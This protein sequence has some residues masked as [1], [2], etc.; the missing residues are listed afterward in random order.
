MDVTLSNLSGRVPN[1]LWCR[2]SI[3]FHLVG[4]HSSHTWGNLHANKDPGLVANT[5]RFEI[6]SHSSLVAS[7]CWMIF[8]GLPIGDEFATAS[9]FLGSQSRGFP[10][11][12]I[13]VH[14]HVNWGEKS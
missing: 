4:N 1:W 6:E 5:C 2:V 3:R 7:I 14:P 8:G 10:V 9:A 13:G 11:F 12:R